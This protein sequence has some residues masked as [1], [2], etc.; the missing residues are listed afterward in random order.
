MPAILAR[1]SPT[2]VTITSAVVDVFFGAMIIPALTLAGV[3]VALLLTSFAWPALTRRRP[4]ATLDRGTTAPRTP[5]PEGRSAWTPSPQPWP[6][7]APAPAP[8]LQ[9]QPTQIQHP[10]GQPVPQYG[11]TTPIHHSPD[12]TTPMWVDNVQDWPQG[13]D[14]DAATQ[15]FTQPGSV[16][17]TPSPAAPGSHREVPPDPRWVEGVGYV[18]DSP[19]DP[20][21]GSGPPA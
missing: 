13:V 12:P 4:A 11:T 21:P 20:G 16:S 10:P 3:G 15:V 1:I 17:S 18:A 7:S 6:D 5:P 2:S 19:S 8:R 9:D 14:P